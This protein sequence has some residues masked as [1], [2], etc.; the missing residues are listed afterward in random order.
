MDMC[1]THTEPEFVDTH[2]K[3]HKSV[4]LS[5]TGSKLIPMMQTKCVC[6]T[7]IPPT[8]INSNDRHAYIK[9]FEK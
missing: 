7:Q 3:G 9:A 5:D 6:E 1:H 2:R 4:G 8:M